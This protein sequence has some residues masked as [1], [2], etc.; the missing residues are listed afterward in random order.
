MEHEEWDLLAVCFDT[1]DHA[2]HLFMRYQAPRMEGVAEEE[3]E[4]YRHVMDG[5]YCFHDM[6]LGR[7]V[8]LSGPDAAIVLVSDH[9]FHS[10]ASRPRGVAAVAHE[11][12]LAWHRGHGVLCMA[13]PG[14]RSDELVYGA[15]LL[16]VAP[17][18]L[19]LLGVAIGDDMQGRVLNEV[20]ERPAV[21]DRIASWE[22]VPGES[23]MAAAESGSAEDLDSSLVLQQLA[24]LGYIDSPAQESE[25]AVRKART[26]NAFNLARVYL[27]QGRPEDALP[28][29]EQV[30]REGPAEATF[31]LHLAQCYYETGRLEECRKVAAAVLAREKDRPAAQLIQANLCLAEGRPEEALGHLAAVEQSGRPAS[32]IRCLAGRVYLNLERWEEAERTFRAVLWSFDPQHGRGAMRLGAGAG[33]ARR[34]AAGRRSRS[35][36]AGIAVRS[37]GGA[38]DAR[39]SV[40]SAGPTRSRSA[41][42]RDVLEVASANGRG[43]R[44][45]GAD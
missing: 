26:Y 8:Q 39:R 44:G 10:G 34:H 41:G 14:I 40:G 35:R 19:A 43:S 16:D 33:R 28:L 37:A 25:E 9:G 4:L 21:W 5:V 31:Q 15:T 42:A 22:D 13:G 18:V 29:M 3:F 45:F 11:T 23:G 17:T 38:L 20:F 36:R 30:A 7:L 24:A 6:M 12:P 1:L 32:G 27:S 2:G